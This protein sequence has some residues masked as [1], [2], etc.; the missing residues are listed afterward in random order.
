[1]YM[2]EV[3]SGKYVPRLLGLL[4][5]CSVAHW[6]LGPPFDARLNAGPSMQIPILV[7]ALR[8]RCNIPPKTKV[9]YRHHGRI[10][11]GK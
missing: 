5:F 9:H 6:A 1:M 8:T 11:R 7:H 10:S 3:M 4:L 2:W